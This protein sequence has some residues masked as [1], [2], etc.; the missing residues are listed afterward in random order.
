MSRPANRRNESDP[1]LTRP[2]LTPLA[3]CNRPLQDLKPY[4]QNA[5]THSSRQIDQIAASIRE[6]GFTNPVLIDSE[7]R[8]IAGHGRVDAAKRLGYTEVPTILLEDMS[9]AQRRAYIIADNR[10]AENAGWDNDILANELQ[11]LLDTEINL[12]VSLTGFDMPE[13]DIIIESAL[14]N[15]GLGDRL[16]TKLDDA[17]AVSRVGDMWELGRHRLLCG[18]ALDLDCYQLL[19]Q[20]DVAEMVFTD[21]PYNVPIDGHVSG[22][23][24]I[25]HE[26]FGMASGEMSVEEFTN[27]LRSAFQNLTSHSTDGSIHF[28]CMD[29]RH[30]PEITTAAGTI[31]SE[32]KNVCV[33]N[34]DNGGMG[35]LYRSKHELIFVFKNGEGTHINNI[36]LGRHGRNRTNVW[37]YPGVNSFSGERAQAQAMHPTVKPLALVSDALLDCSNRNG[38]ILDPFSGSG[39]ALIAAERVGRRARC[40]ELDPLYVD[41]AIRRWQEETGE[42]AVDIKTGLGFADI[43]KSRSTEKTR[44]GTEGEGNAVGDKSDD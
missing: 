14:N 26:E 34:K 25:Q 32:T 8:I 19:M 10:L 33:W 39:T 31:Y 20:G 24:A 23:G 12:D 28:I 5:R 27:F 37:D 44:Q 4:E 36:E 6:F 42:H 22:L 9:D 13:I 7:N 2:V 43:E 17:P 11:F 16:P 38:I 18:D 3:V 30:I 29:W 1:K 41:V 15:T 21:P 35:S 40:I